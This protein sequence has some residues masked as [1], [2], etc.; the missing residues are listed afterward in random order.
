MRPTVPVRQSLLQQASGICIARVPSHVDREMDCAGRRGRGLL[1]AK[2]RNVD[3]CAV[4]SAPFLPS[5]LVKV[6]V[7]PGLARL[8]LS[9]STLSEASRASPRGGQEKRHS[10]LVWD[11]KSQCRFLCSRGAT[12][13]ARQRLLVIDSSSLQSTLVASPTN[14]C[15]FGLTLYL[16]QYL[17]SR[18]M[19][20]MSRHLRWRN[21]RAHLPVSYARLQAWSLEHAVIERPSP[22][23]TAAFESPHRIAW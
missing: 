20:R 2:I 10:F 16:L 14:P 3:F 11:D 15:F 1:P 6:K 12:V 21:S 7:W 4:L 23:A 8:A 19:F 5:L 18:Y 17:S 22:G 13:P 9:S